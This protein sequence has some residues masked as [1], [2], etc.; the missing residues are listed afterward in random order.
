M[1]QNGTSQPPHPPNYFQPVNIIYMCSVSYHFCVVIFSFSNRFGDK[2]K[3]F[4]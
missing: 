2:V 4:F 3:H 1:T